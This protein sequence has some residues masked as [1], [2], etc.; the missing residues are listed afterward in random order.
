VAYAD[1]FKA[2][3]V[4]PS[5]PLAVMRDRHFGLY[6]EAGNRD[7]AL[8]AQGLI[9]AV[10]PH[11]VCILRRGVGSSLEIRFSNR[12]RRFVYLVFSEDRPSI[13]I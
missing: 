3:G 2:E 1:K 12:D 13:R 9:V 10:Q 7:R 5:A 8:D 6:P 11:R 4:R